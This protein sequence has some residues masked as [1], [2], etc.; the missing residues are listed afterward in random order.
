M[1]TI[2]VRDLRQRWPAAERRL[3][4]ELELIITRDGRPIARLVRLARTNTQ[5]RRFSPQAHSDWRRQVPANHGDGAGSDVPRRDWG[6]L[7]G[8]RV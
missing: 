4:T 3:E 6:Q 7:V 5:R 2:T 8:S 1:N